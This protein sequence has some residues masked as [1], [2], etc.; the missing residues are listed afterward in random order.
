MYLLDTNVISETVKKHP[1]RA[2]LA[3]FE[4]VAEIDLH[5]SLLSLGEIRTGVEKLTAG[6]SRKRLAAFLEA[7]LPQRFAVRL[8][9]VNYDVVDR[10]G[11][12][13]AAHGR[14][15]PP[16]DS[17]LAATALVHGLTIVT[18]NMRDFGIAGLASINPWNFGG[19]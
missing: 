7:E 5:L 9:P 12:L 17:L 18:R 13:R 1:S 3:W 14:T 10:W 19:H 16:I 15:L 2:V 4:S 8:L 11:R 6:P